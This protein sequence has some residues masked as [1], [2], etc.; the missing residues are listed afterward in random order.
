MAGGM[1][2][3]MESMGVSSHMSM[4]NI[5]ME[6]GV[7][8]AR[9]GV[10]SARDDGT[11]KLLAAAT[12]PVRRW[13]ERR[14]V[15]LASAG[16][17]FIAIFVL[18]ELTSGTGYG[19]SLLYVVPVAL[20][21][22][23]LGLWAGVVS[24]ALAVG[25]VAVWIDTR[26]TGLDALALIVRSA[27]FLAVGVIAGRF[28]D[29]MRA[30]IVREEHLLRSGLDLA[31]L[32][33]ADSLADSLAEHVRGAV[34]AASVRVE[35]AGLPAV[36]IGQPA[37]GSLRVPIVSHGNDLGSLEV[38]WDAKRRFTPEDRLVLETLALQA[39]VAS[40]NR[41]LFAV[42]REQAALRTEIGRMRRRLGDQLRNAS[43]VL[44]RHEQERRGIAHQLHE[45]AAQAMAAALLA[46]GLLERGIEREATQA[47]LE[48]VRS[49]V[50]ASIVDLRRIAGSLRPAV[51]DEM[52]LVSALAGIS[53]LEA[54]Y[55]V[56][57]VTFSTDDMSARLPREAET[58]IYRVIEEVLD[59]MNLA[60]TIGVTLTTQAE[61]ARLV[62]DA[63]FADG[64]GAR[65]GENERRLNDELVATRA[66][67]ELIGG[68]LHIGSLDGEG[69]RVIAE[70]PLQS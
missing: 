8:S 32:G 53:E 15:V 18:R 68:S 54:E 9:D 41:R 22:L 44:E 61:V 7:A 70:I 42:E 39:A 6:N 60:P 49:Q 26:S 38:G 31:R 37:E 48:G 21:A 19:L 12:A 59:A 1:Q 55:G 65:G 51:L 16:A 62:I 63:G 45:E 10:D 5:E 69:V 13:P 50:K 3:Y 30:N 52:G 27:I 17:L 23:E 57:S 28:S 58:S 14:M 35:L 64:D 2:S 25:A 20:V 24:A 29:R 46:V 56:R 4:I 40:D 66:R 43:Q 47:Q 34:G 67:V 33:E 11:S 36:S